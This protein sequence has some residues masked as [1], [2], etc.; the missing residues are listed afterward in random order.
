MFLRCLQS[1]LQAFL[2]AFAATATF[3]A[4]FS[5]TFFATF[6]RQ[7]NNRSLFSARFLVTKLAEIL[8]NLAVTATFFRR[9][10]RSFFERCL[11]RERLL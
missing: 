9:G 3:S 4:T 5:A 2:H 7:K 1:F 6:C 11:N 8:Q 10:A